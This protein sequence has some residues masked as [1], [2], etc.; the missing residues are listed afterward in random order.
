M[1]ILSFKPQF[2]PKIL[3]G[4]KKHTIRADK[5]NRWHNKMTIHFATG[6]RTPQYEKFDEKTC[7]AT[8]NI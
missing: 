1:M 8:I 2:V 7:C 3:D 5:H 4:T 6:V